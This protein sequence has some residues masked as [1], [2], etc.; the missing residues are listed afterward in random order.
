MQ[1]F[2]KGQDLKGFSFASIINSPKK[3]SMVTS[4]CFEATNICWVIGWVLNPLEASWFRM[5]ARESITKTAAGTYFT[6]SRIDKQK[7]YENPGLLENLQG[8]IPAVVNPRKQVLVAKLIN[9]LHLNDAKKSLSL[10][11]G[12]LP[13]TVTTRIITCLA[14]SMA[15]RP[16]CQSL[17]FLLLQGAIS[18]LS[19]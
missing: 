16:D 14:S 5:C 19:H 1:N 13:V 10:W 17:H 15:P 12:P 7:V 11:Y 18:N 2:Q 6:T 9:F 8:Y 4:S 3:K